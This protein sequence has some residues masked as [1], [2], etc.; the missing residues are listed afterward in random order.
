MAED[1]QGRVQ[2]T[3][4]KT[5]NFFIADYNDGQW[6]FSEKDPWE[7]RWH[8]VQATLG[9]IKMAED[10]FRQENQ[11]QQFFAETA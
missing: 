8:P 2:W 1:L 7:V 3:D 10:L 4:S 6:N 11:G 9:L 5:G